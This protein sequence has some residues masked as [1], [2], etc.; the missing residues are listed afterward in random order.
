MELIFINSTQT[1]T[2]PVYMKQD[3]KIFS[4]RKKPMFLTQL[5]H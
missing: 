5:Q 1:S 2:V 4:L 3:T